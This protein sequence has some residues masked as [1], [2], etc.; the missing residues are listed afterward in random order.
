V[1]TTIPA[2]TVIDLA[3]TSHPERVERILD[4]AWSR[5]LLGIG[6][7][8]NILDEVRG[9]GRSGSRLI[10]ELVEARKFKPRPGSA[11]EMH[12]VRGLERFGLPALRRQVHLSDEE[13]WIGCVDFVAETASV[14]LFI[15]G[16]AWHTS[17]T[18]RR[19][20]DR[21]TTRIRALGYHVERI[22]DLEVLY[23]E[24]QLMDRLRPLLARSCGAPVPQM[25]ARTDE[26]TAA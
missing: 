23:E 6:E 25:R 24:P 2:R 17:V 16:A 4:A 15:D 5:R 21:Q 26:V 14:V 3:A 13:G 22:T 19:H 11:L 7:V 10:A 20:D 9:K 8:A 18:D 1:P 12:F